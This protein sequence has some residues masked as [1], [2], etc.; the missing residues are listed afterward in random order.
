MRLS[1]EQ[2]EKFK[3]LHEH[4]GLLEAFSEQQIEEI[5]NGVAN[6]FIQLFEM[7]LRYKKGKNE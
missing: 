7:K 6:Y 5:A 1:S 2:I 4:T 3:R